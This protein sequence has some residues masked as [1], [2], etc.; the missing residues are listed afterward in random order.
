[1]ETNNCMG[2]EH[3]L[4]EDLEF[5]GYHFT[6]HTNFVI[7]NAATAQDTDCFENPDEFRPERWLDGRE[8]DILHGTTTFG[9][10]R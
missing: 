4:T 9:G 10:G 3:C 1:V 5:E 2:T 6:K 8:S 7:N